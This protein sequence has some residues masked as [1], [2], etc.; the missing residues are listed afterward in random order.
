LN[1]LFDVVW[2]QPATE[3]VES[4]F[5]YIAHENPLAANRIRDKIL[6]AGNS[7][8]QFPLRGRIGSMADTREL[9]I[10]RRYVVVYAVDG[11]RVTVL[12]VWHRSQRRS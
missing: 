8:E 10:D 4:Q 2:S 9:V 11:N 7:L 5:S 12:R 3:D 1:A 6:D